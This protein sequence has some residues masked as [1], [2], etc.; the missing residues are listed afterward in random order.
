VLPVALVF[1]VWDAVAIA[2]HIWTYNPRYISG[3]ELPAS[4]PV[5]ELLF[6]IVI[7]VCGLLTYS[8]VDTILTFLQRIRAR[9]EQQS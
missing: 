7:P 2:A 3:L 4:M 5:V 1:A 8:A 9:S 6:F